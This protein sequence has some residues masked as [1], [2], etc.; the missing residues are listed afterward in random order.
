MKKFK[1]KLS[2]ILGILLAVPSILQGIKVLAGFLQPDQIVLIWLVVY[3]LIIGIM[4]LYVVFKIWE[5]AELG[6]KLAVLVF[7]LHLS[8]L[9]VLVFVYYT[10]GMVAMKSI[11]A[12]V[13]RSSIWGIIVYLTRTRNTVDL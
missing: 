13:V 3:N 11:M 8:V 1:F 9:I 2:A 12:M 4:S 10:T 7:L 5:N 6:K